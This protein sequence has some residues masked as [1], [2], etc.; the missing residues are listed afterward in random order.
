MGN[1]TQ[2]E[3]QDTNAQSGSVSEFVNIAA[4]RFVE[5]ENLE[6]RRGSLRKLCEDLQLRGTILLSPEG[7]NLFLAG[8]RDAI[9]RFV[10]ELTSDAPF[11]G[12]E[13]KESLSDHQPFNRTLVKIKK[14]IIA[15]G[16]DGIE[17]ARRT[18]PKLSATELKKWLDESRPV[19]LLDTRNDY[20][21]KVGTF[22]GAVDLDID[23]FRQ[24]PEAI[25][26]LPDD[27]KKQPVVMFCTGGIRC[28]KAGPFMEQEGFEQI[29]Q[30]DGGI[31]KYFEECGG[32]H[33]DGECFVFDHRVAV[34]AELEETETQQCFACQ[35]PLTDEDLKSERYVVAES[36]PHCYEEP[37]AKARRLAA[38]RDTLVDALIDP[39]PGDRPDDEFHPVV[40]TEETAGQPLI[41][42]LTAAWPAISREEWGDLF[43]QERVVLKD[44]AVEPDQI[45]AAGQRYGRLVPRPPEPAV[46]ARLK[47][48]YEDDE[49]VVIDKP[50][51]LPVRPE[52]GFVRNSASWI[53]AELYAPQRPQPAM[54]VSRE[55]AGAV[56][57][58]RTRSEARR[59]RPLIEFGEVAGSPETESVSAP[60][61]ESLTFNHPVR[62]ETVTITR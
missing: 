50:A 8:T 34:G 55:T 37:I 47:V 25:R 61:V 29:Y 39:L 10:T 3:T 30:L 13:I 58:G 49:I 2:S 16:I 5:L 21:V 14:E 23:H 18:S 36:C 31:L 35:M 45:V 22:E 53:L 56:V 48:L 43:Q 42:F 27:L 9:D 59:L 40:V 33:W 15:F 4:Y 41:D 62:R 46:D 54:D 38:E 19:T 17:P 32:D 7:I 24:F 6:E 1:E 57:F 51:G 44:R 11:A 12:M 52:G 28:E 60:V 20:E 26:Q